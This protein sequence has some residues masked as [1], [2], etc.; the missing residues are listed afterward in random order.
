MKPLFFLFFTISFLS[1]N[2]GFSQQKISSPFN[3]TEFD[4]IQHQRIYRIQVDGYQVV[5]LVEFNNNKFEGTLT[6]LVWRLNRKEITKDSLIQKIAIPHHTVKKL[7]HE[8]GNADFEY[9]SDCD[10]INNCI[11]GLDGTTTTFQSENVKKV[12]AAS[13]WELESD[14]YYHQNNIEIPDEIL[15]ARKLISM[16]NNEFN[17][18]DQFKS[19][20]NRLPKGRYRYGMVIMKKG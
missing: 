14:Y 13:Y 20:L 9:L 4:S 15:K 1:T 17:L 6:H 18:D 19:F 11:I 5:E 3:L 8:L 10:E 12:N 2:L 16:I 7:M